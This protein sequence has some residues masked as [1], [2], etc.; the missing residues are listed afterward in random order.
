[1]TIENPESR[2]PNPRP[3][4]QFRGAPHYEQFHPTWL[5]RIDD[6]SPE[7]IGNP[8]QSPSHALRAGQKLA[9]PATVKDPEHWQ[10]RPP[11]PRA[12]GRRPALQAAETEFPAAFADEMIRT[13]SD[14]ELR[15]M[16]RRGELTVPGSFEEF[17]ALVE[18]ALGPQAPDSELPIAGCRSAMEE[19]GGPGEAP[20]GNRPST[21]GNSE[22][23]S[24]L[25]GLAES[26]WSR[27]NVFSPRVAE[28]R[29]LLEATLVW[30]PHRFLR[31]WLKL[32]EVDSAFD[33]VDFFQRT[34][35]PGREEIA[36]GDDESPHP[37]RAKPRPAVIPR[38]EAEGRR[39]HAGELQHAL[40]I[41]FAALWH[42]RVPGLRASHKVTVALYEWAVSRFGIRE[43]FLQ[44]R[45][46][47]SM[48]QRQTRRERP[49]W[50]VRV[51]TVTGKTLVKLSDGQIFE[52]EK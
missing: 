6:L 5:E 39:I 27:M 9:G 8:F 47:L 42:A 36:W 16:V 44:W 30:H 51:T 12:G 1:L 43:E 46:E 20:M 22:S 14:R 28:L 25:H 26:L 23:R 35:G 18:E 7:A 50:A 31:L 17:R 19:P 11:K 29:E 15:R 13:P 21:I 40:R 48:A 41:A 3:L 52:P 32:L 33:A 45:P 49:E 10:E 2:P 24:Y 4:L 37:E 38:S 34:H